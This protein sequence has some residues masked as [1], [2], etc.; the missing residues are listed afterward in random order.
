MR[1][2]LLL[3][4]LVFAIACEGNPA[5]PTDSQTDDDQSQVQ[6]VVINIVSPPGGGGGGDGKDGGLNEA[7]IVENPGDQE[8]VAQELANVQIRAVDPD[9][10]VLSYRL[11]NP[12]RGLSIDQQGLIRGTISHSSPA[13]SP[14]F[15]TVTVND[16]TH[17]TPVSFTW[18]VTIPPGSTPPEVT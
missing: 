3:L 16:G 17:V 6:T 18:V 9:G 10:D 5:G 14:F 1:K 15:V 8:N 11:I 4:P 7:P 13:D 2:L 12:P